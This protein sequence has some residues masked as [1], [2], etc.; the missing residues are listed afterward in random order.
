VGKKLGK[1]ERVQIQIT[2]YEQSH[3]M[4]AIP[5]I[6]AV[7]LCVGGSAVTQ[8]DASRSRVHVAG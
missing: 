4:V 8:K 2:Q 5:F 3:L 1:E 7:Y 6:S